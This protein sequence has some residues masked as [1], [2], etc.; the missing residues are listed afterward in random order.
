MNIVTPMT[1]VSGLLFS[2]VG[3]SIAQGQAA[4]DQPDCACTT[5]P[6]ADQVTE[7]AG[8]IVRKT[9]GV[10]YAGRSQTLEVVAGTPMRRG[11]EYLVGPSGELRVSVGQNCIETVGANSIATVDELL[12]DN[13]R[14]CLRVRD[15]EAGLPDGS[16]TTAQRIIGVGAVVGVGVG[17]YLLIRSK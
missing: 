4:L 8:S 1:I 13:G 10:S 3:A 17:G 14:L 7:I 2:M 11:V 12:T 16:L 5:L 9:G 6:N 15:I